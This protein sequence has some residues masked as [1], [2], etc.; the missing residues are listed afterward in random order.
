M[1]ISV[2]SC[3]LVQPHRVASMAL[4]AY[5]FHTGQNLS[6]HC[7]WFLSSVGTGNI[8][9]HSQV[10]WRCRS[11]GY[12]SALAPIGWPPCQ[13]LI[14][15][16]HVQLQRWEGREMAHSSATSIICSRKKKWCNSECINEEFFLKEVLL[17]SGCSL[18]RYLIFCLQLFPGFRGIR[19]VDVEEKNAN[20]KGVNRLKCM[21]LHTF[22]KLLHIHANV[23]AKM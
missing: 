7:L 10:K 20:G 14:G 12:L 1:L 16:A 19:D 3:A 13:Y 22:K 2:F 6:G 11:Q 21:G 17:S 4:D 5:S 23:G 18:M 8:G 9:I 15:S